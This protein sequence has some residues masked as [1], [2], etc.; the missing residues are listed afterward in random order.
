M[1][2]PSIAIWLRKKVIVAI[3]IGLWAINTAMLI[4]GESPPLSLPVTPTDV[5]W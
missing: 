1:E 3:V 4:S 5:V 2:L